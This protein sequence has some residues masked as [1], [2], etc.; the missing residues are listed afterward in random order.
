[1]PLFAGSKTSTSSDASPTLLTFSGTNK[2]CRGGSPCIRQRRETVRVYRSNYDREPPAPSFAYYGPFRQLLR[3][4]GGVQHHK[5]G[6]LIEA[7]CRIETLQAC[8]SLAVCGRDSVCDIN[9]IGSQTNECIGLMQGQRED[10]TGTTAIQAHGTINSG[11]M[12]IELP[13]VLSTDSHSQAFG[14]NIRGKDSCSK[15]GSRICHFKSA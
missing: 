1:M 4:F 14:W 12:V 15:H 5:Y 7:I 11:M 2:S 8:S 9:N 13:L 6:R 10:I 3:E